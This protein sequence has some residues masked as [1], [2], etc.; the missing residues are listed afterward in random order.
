MLSAVRRAYTGGSHGAAAAPGPIAGSAEH[1][2]EVIML[3]LSLAPLLLYSVGFAGY[4]GNAAN[5]RCHI[6]HNEKTHERR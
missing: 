1:A 5:H 3:C 2:N 6:W 4:P